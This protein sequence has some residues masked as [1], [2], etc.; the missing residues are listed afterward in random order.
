MT[1]AEMEESMIKDKADRI[2][3]LEK[4]IDEMT[5]KLVE[6]E[7]KLEQHI[8]QLNK[9]SKEVCFLLANLKLFLFTFF[10]EYY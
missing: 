9:L 4:D 7:N 6:T 10:Q 2:A 8:T 3:D 1:L 5:G